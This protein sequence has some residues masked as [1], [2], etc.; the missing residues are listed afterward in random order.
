MNSEDIVVAIICGLLVMVV[1]CLP[2]KIYIDYQIEIKK[3]DA[4]YEA[5]KNG[6]KLDLSLW[7]KK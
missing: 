5:A 1:L 6:V 4:L 3:A 2:V 7:E